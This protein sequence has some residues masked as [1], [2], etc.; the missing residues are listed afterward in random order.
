MADTLCDMNPKVELSQYWKHDPRV[1]YLNHGS[2]GGTPSAV[3]AAQNALRERMESELIRFFV[4]D[5]EGLADGARRALGSFVNCDWD[6][7]APVPNATFGVTT[8]LEHLA[9]TGYVGPGDE[10]LTNTHEYPAC[11][12][13][14]KRAA[15]K[16]GAVVVNAEIPFPVESSAGVVSSIVGKVT[17]KTRVALVSHVTSSTGMVLPIAEIVKALEARGVRTLVDGAH[18]PGMLPLDL[19]AIGASYYTANCHKWICSP[20]GSAFLYVRRD[21]REGLRPLVLSNNAEK[22]KPGRH[23]FLTEFEYVGTQD[24]TAFLSIPAAIEFMGSI[25]PGGWNEVMERNHALCLA[26]RNH[27]CGRLGIRP[28]VPDSMIGTISTMVLPSHEPERHARLMA[29]PSKYHDA[30]QDALIAKHGIQVPIW[31]LAGKPER[32]VRISAQ[33]YNSMEQY[34]RLASALLEEL[35]AERNL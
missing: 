2:Y 20:K 19:K 28:P 25:F 34:E 35:E 15:A 8:V 26:G 7:I 11:Q 9:T 12:N 33:V 29:R 4:E 1:T 13:N 27:V 18:A 21:L 22:P 30:L 23:Q 6:C 5:Y 3:M 31:G 32:F 10:V 14:L 17:P 16:C 24:Y